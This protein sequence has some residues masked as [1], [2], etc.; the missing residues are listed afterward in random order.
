MFDKNSVRQAYHAG[1]YSINASRLVNTLFALN[2][3]TQV[4]GN[5]NEAITP[6]VLRRLYPKLKEQ[7]QENKKTDSES[8]EEDVYIRQVQK[9]A[10]LPQYD[11]FGDYSEMALQVRAAP[12]SI[13]TGI[14]AEMSALERSSVTSCFGAPAGL[15]SLSPRSSTIS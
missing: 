7:K 4:I 6:F 3:T 11:L 8:S 5:V 15:L 10:G 2:T 13:R 1:K 12:L 9:E 14:I